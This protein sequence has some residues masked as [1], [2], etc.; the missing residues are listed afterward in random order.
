MVQSMSI[1]AMLY[2][3]KSEN[4]IS[5]VLT[6]HSLM[7]D[8]QSVFNVF[9]NLYH[10]LRKKHLLTKPSSKSFLID[11]SPW[12]DNDEKAIENTDEICSEAFLC[13]YTG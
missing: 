6:V 7:A 13:T 2:S 9:I 1:K 3:L 12:F 8:K 4:T 11:G 5:W 10:R